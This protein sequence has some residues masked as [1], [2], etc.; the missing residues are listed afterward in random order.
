MYLR[1]AKL[2]L[3]FSPIS[4]AIALSS[5]LF[6]PVSFALDD[7]DVETEQDVERI[8]IQGEAQTQSGQFVSAS[9]GWVSGDTL[10]ERPMLRTGEMLEFIPG[11]MVTQHSGSGKANQYFLRGFN[12][13]H[14][15]DFAVSVDGMP[16]NMRSHGH[17]Q[18]YSDLNFVIP[19]MVDNL[20]YFKGTYYANI[21][22]FSSAGGAYFS[23]K[24]SLESNQLLVTLG[25]DN[26]RRA[27]T[28]NSASIGKGTAIAAL[29]YQ[30]YDGPWTDIDEDVKKKNAN[31]RYIVPLFDGELAISGMAYENSWNS[32]DQV[33]ARAIESGLIDRL[34]SIDT[35]VGGESSRYSLSA[36]YNSDTVNASLYAIDTDLTLF[37]NFTYFLDNPETGDQFE[38]ADDRKIYGG[39][40]ST[41]LPFA[42]TQ[43]SSIT[44]GGQWRY[45]DIGNVGLYRTQNLERLSTIREDAIDSS[46]YA[47]FAQSNIVL[48]DSL[49]LSLGGRY[50][51]FDIEVDSQIA[52]NSGDEK[53]GMFSLK[54]G[55]KYQYTDTMT[56][57]ANIGQ[58]YHSNDAR[59][60][61]IT[62]DPTTGESI[63]SAPL[64]VRSLGYETGINWT[65]N[66]TYN[67]S[68]ALWQLELDSELVYVGDAGFTE[69]SRPSKRYGIEVS[70]YYWLSHHLTAD[71]EAAYTKARFSD[72]VA[73]EGDHI[74]GT[75][76]AVV[77]AGA[78]WYQQSNQQGF[79]YTLRARYLSS[80]TVDSFDTIEPPSTFLLNTQIAYQD[81]DWQI[82][83][84]VLNLLDSDA[85]DIDYYYASRLPGEPE[86]G[87][88]DLH[89][90]P[91][92]PRT[93]RL[94]FGIKY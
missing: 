22:D 33:P 10:I 53:D 78:T 39:E 1:F 66:K 36:Q 20:S 32:A 26:Y 85:H 8:R 45:D 88:E 94:T 80:R 79:S 86:E 62:Q 40:L 23:S 6:I 52:A 49:T 55:L 29:E 89:Y 24:D 64:L 69:A 13:D 51:Y 3:R 46:S 90:H 61:T 12:L 84:E 48:S 93:V 11:M 73:G 75:V 43:G 30:T 47:A 71:I 34:G 50:D 25:E 83:L 5:T 28:L 7:P 91:V 21:G 77:S 9:Q 19:E 68:A 14:G 58:G 74:D 2:P 17:G 87:V 37:S 76:P 41:T 44:L 63:A 35:Q 31:L 57:F 65:D 27:V 70:A 82:G 67:V 81:T 54:S 38:Q 16:V 92:E 42:V 18:G 56:M 72:T 60:V 4:I 59:G 15:T